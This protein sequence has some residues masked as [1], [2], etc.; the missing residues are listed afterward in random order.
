MHQAM[1]VVTSTP[2]LERLCAASAGIFSSL[3]SSMWSDRAVDLPLLHAWL[4][5]SGNRQFL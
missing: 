2:D 4:G 1:D 5:R 3:D